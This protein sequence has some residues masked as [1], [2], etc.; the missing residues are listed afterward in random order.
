MDY[1]TC[2]FPELGA[3]RT[4]DLQTRP[5]QILEK[6]SEW[7]RVRPKPDRLGIIQGERDPKT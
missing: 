7:P 3:N 1:T 2:T 6:L 5:V 4:I